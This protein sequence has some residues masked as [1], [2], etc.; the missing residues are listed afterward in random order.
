MRYTTLNFKGKTAFNAEFDDIYFNT[1]KPEKESAFVFTSVFDTLLDTKDS[2]IVGEAGFGAGL[3]FLTLCAK[4]LK[5]DKKLHYVSIEKTPFCVDDLAK[6]YQKLG[7]FKGLVKR[8]IKIYPPLSSGIFRLEFHKNITLDLCFGEIF[9]TLK[10]LDFKAD[11]WFLDGFSPAKNPQM[12]SDEV[13]SEIARLTRQD[14]VVCTYS[15]AKIV[16]ENLEK[17]GFLVTLLKGYAKKRQ[18]IRAVLKNPP[19]DDIKFSYFSRPQSSQNLKNALIIGGGVTGILTAIE[20]KKLGLNVKIA[21]KMN[22]V[23]TNGSSNLSGI[24][25]PLITKNGVKLGA[26]HKNAFLNASSFYKQNAPKSVAKFT[27]C[28][29][30]AYDETL[31]KRYKDATLNDAHIYEFNEQSSPYPHIFCR[32][33]ALMHPKKM[34]KILSKNLHI[35]FNHEYKSHKHLKNG[36]I[37]VKFQDKTTIKTDILIF[38]SGSH[39]KEIFKNLP[40][41]FVR[42]QVTHIKTSF[43]PPYPISAKGYITPCYNGVCVVGATYLR[44]EIFNAPKPSDDIEN[45]EKISEFL[46]KNEVKIVKS[47]VA[48]RSYSSD[49]APIISPLFDE[50]FYKTAYKKLFWLKHKG[51]AT[52]P[53]YEPNVYL[54]IAHGSRGLGTAVLGARLVADYIKNRPLCIQKSLAYELHAA[55]FLIRKLKKGQE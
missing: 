37:S 21:E 15:S 30:Y 40:L 41:S 17:N 42:G 12:W 38:C 52:P 44:N 50:N 39:S 28:A 5:T 35:L 25:M 34:C 54:N 31:I 11:V 3:N 13:M 55:R 53:K 24:L 4:F 27:G 46:G 47:N 20:L 19:K 29:D 1:Q 7:V 48:Y 23:A 18:M 43:N 2:F 9:D 45:L 26:M 36:K 51:I 10:E 6:I 22:E 32:H 16:R 49:R 8:L 33:S 14:G